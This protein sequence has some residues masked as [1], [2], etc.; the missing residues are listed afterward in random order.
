MYCVWRLAFP[1]LEELQGIITDGLGM[2]D[3][4]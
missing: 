1:W 3:F 2:E 4:Y